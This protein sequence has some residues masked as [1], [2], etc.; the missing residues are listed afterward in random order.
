MDEYINL[1][2]E[3]A[4]RTSTT[5]IAGLTDQILRLEPE[6]QKSDDRI[7][8][9]LGTNDAALL[10][11]ASSVGNY[12]TILYQQQAAAQSEYD[13]LQSM[14]LDQNLLLE[15]D[16]TPALMSG[17]YGGVQA[18][19]LLSGGL[20]VNPG[21]VE[22]SDLFAP[23]TIG[24]QYL[25]IKQQILLLTAEQKRYEEFLKPKHP[26]MIAL[27]R[28]ID[29][30]TQLLDI[31]R[32]QNVEQMDAK[33]SALTLQITNLDKQAKVW[34]LQNI[35]LSRKSAQ[36]ARLKARSDR[37]QALYDSLLASLETLD[38]NKDIS[39]ESVTVYEPATDATRTKR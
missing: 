2:K 18:G 27:S 28:E 14:T 6:M 35:E 10:Q 15:Q 39:P 32:E 3:M 24:M 8:A 26:Q 13:L 17:A 11:E 7:Q 19:A 4:E 25:T 5:T 22:Q 38:V 37:I 30:F 20:P 23:N 36:Y 34:G 31:Y 1:K 29:Q 12:L 9:F 33:K 21:M 16:R